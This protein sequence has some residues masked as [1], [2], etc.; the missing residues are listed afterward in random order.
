VAAAALSVLLLVV[1]VA[2]LAA[3]AAFAA[4]ALRLRSAASFA[5]ATFLLG[6]GEVVV[7]TELLSLPRLVGAAGY[8]AAEAVLLAAAVGAWHLR[9][10]PR[11]PV[12]KLERGD[13]RRNPIVAGLAV[14]VLAGWLY[15]LVIV[16]TTTPNNGDAL[17]YHLPRAAAWLQHGGL[18]E[19]E[20][21]HTERQNEFP[22]NAE[23][24]FLY[25]FAFLHGDELAALPQLL[26]G[27]ALVVAVAGCA[28]RLGFGRAPA[29]F[30]GLLTAT[31]S[32]IVLQTVTT[33]NDLVAAAFVV[34][35]AYFVR[36]DDRTELGLAGLAIG[37][38][39]G[40]K[41]TAYLALPTLA[42]LALVSLPWRRLAALA[43]AT[44]AGFVAVAAYVYVQNLRYAGDPL[45]RRL[46][47]VIFA[48][49]VTAAGT[50]STLARI[51]YQFVDL[52]G[53]RVRTSWLEPVE[54]AGEAA[55]DALGIPPNPKESA[56]FPF[57]FTVNVVAH[58]D[59][60][61]FGPLGVLL[62][63]PL[64][65][66]F[67]VAW[68]LRRTSAPRG[69]HALA[70]PLYALGLALILR[71]SDEGRYLVA[72]VA[73]TMP[74]AASLYRFRLAAAG[75]AGI[76]ALSLAFAHAYNE[77]RPLGLGSDEAAWRQTRAEAFGFAEASLTP[78]VAA[79]DRTVPDDARLGAVLAFDDP[80]YPL[81]GKRLERRLVDLPSADPLGA[82]E[83]RGLRWV[84]LGRDQDVPDDP[85]WT[86]VVHSRSGTLLA[87]V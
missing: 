77:A 23:I 1:G 15:G 69:L 74:L 76:G 65:L 71:F 7:V 64:S 3:T 45:G 43:T 33:K 25:T 66:V 54:D 51:G 18:H 80:D 82:A 19:I 60:A 81:Y 27:I 6:Y 17:N 41:L 12:P 47:Q 9:G 86:V 28:R 57:T 87:R 35:G 37:L 63:L 34:A 31:L 26:A 52:T 8:L 5:L 13:V 2:A 68:A 39:L 42:L 59:H 70:L 4:A 67:A 84:V 53:Y 14:V 56:G 55:F 16:S 29:L 24:G 44:V 73:L 85:G 58:E 32:E 11:P 21:A 36:R 10:R 22:P 50:V 61:F 48:P 78:L 38:A 62:V 20:D 49:D 83:R 46:E 79:L 30:A 75:A 40:T 72:P